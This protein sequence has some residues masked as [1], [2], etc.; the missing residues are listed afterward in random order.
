MEN[1]VRVSDTPWQSGELATAVEGVPDTLYLA[2]LLP[3]P[4]GVPRRPLME[5]PQSRAAHFLVA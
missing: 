1:L 4:G 3:P 5:N 2:R